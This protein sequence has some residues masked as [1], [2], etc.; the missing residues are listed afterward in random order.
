MIDMENEPM[1]MEYCYLGKSGL[2]VS[3]IGLG[4]VPFGT[5]MDEATCRSVVDLYLDVGGNYIDTA[6][7]YGGGTRANNEEMAGTSERTVAKVIKGRRERFIVATKGAW[8]MTNTM[9]PNAFGLSRKYLYREIEASLQRLETDYIDLFQCH[10]WDPYTPI[11]ETMRALDDLVRAGK[12]RYVGVSNW[13]GWHVV[14]ANTFA[15]Q[16]SLSPVVSNQIWY[17]L[18]DRVAEF[19]IIPACRDQ[20]VAVIAWGVYAEGFLTGR[21]RRGATGPRPGSRFDVLKD[22]EMCSWKNLA[23]ERN[24]DLI[25]VMDRIAKRHSKD[26]VNVAMAWILQSGQA[27]VALLGVSSISQFHSSMQVLDF[28]LSDQE[29]QELKVISEL[30]HPYPMNFWDLFCYHDSE[31]YGGIR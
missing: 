14:K 1:A 12:V 23:V 31:F 28:K 29:M 27:D 11:E 16:H 7:I 3:C 25:D 19:S 13:D 17:T 22:S 30:P 21:Y 10:V 15:R 8:M 24:W 6:N 4:T 2:K 9:W 26:L 18:A 20:D 5:W